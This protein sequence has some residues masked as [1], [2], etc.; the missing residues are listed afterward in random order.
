MEEKRY[1]ILFPSHTEGMKLEAL[2]KE[3]H[4]KHTIVPTPRELSSSCGIAIMYNLKD[5]QL[6]V[7][8]I[9][10]NDINISGKKSITKKIKNYYLD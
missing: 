10:D 7:R 2:L 3:A 5:E 1:Y 9:K 8:I 6:I 4:I